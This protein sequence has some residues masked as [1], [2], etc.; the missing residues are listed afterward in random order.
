MS[1]QLDRRQFLRSSALTAAATLGSQ[2]LP[3]SLLAETTPAA[4]AL[5]SFAYADITFA[6]GLHEAQRHQTQSVLQSLNLDSLLKPYRQR[7]GLPAPGVDL[8]GWYD[9]YAFCP[10]HTLGQWLSALS[11]S[12]AIDGNPATLARVQQIVRTF[13]QYQHQDPTG[14]FYR[15]NRFPGYITEKLNCGLSDAYAIAHVDEAA[16]ALALLTRRALPFLPEKALSRAEQEARPH[17]DISYTW[18]ETYTLPENYFLAWQRTG[19]RRYYDLGARF[20]YDSF[21]KPLAAGDN[22]LPGKHAYSHLNSLNSAAQAYLA[23]GDTTYLKAAVNGFEF[24]RQQSYATGGWG[25]NEAFV[26]P[27]QGNLGK[28]LAKTHAS[29]ETPCGAYGESKITRTLLTITANP[30][31]GDEM[32]RVMYNTVLGARPLGADGAAFYYSDYNPHGRKVYHPDMWPCC[33][34]TITQMAA[35]YR[36][37]TYLHDARGVYVNLYIPSVVRWQRPAGVLTLS[38]QS[39]Y[40]LDG[41]IYFTI[42]TPQPDTFAL[43]LRIPAWAAGAT[44]SINGQQQSITVQPGTFAT[45]D[46][47]WHDG[48]RVVLNLPLALRLLPVDPETPKTVALVRGPLVLFL[49]APP[50]QL[51][52]SKATVPSL[53]ESAL[54][55][56]ERIDTD[57]WLI[58]SP[59]DDIRLRPFTSLQDQRYHTYTQLI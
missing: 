37:S 53:K 14:A 47:T 13:N 39:H 56:A 48:D 41:A 18:D 31:Y 55:N 17:K 33:A 40:P 38:Q 35:D 1:F 2:A 57:E 28:S 6:P 34:G 52:E 27:G 29:F 4:P 50:F 12:Y 44:V 42:G 19:D 36:L 54:L 7:A 58:K 23:L 10:G 9:A 26:V 21:F 25:P 46:R 16:E 45:L 22:V 32:E 11:R 30:L 51:D 15:D 20:V 43:R 24:V 49:L 5:Q 59:T 8:G 3:A